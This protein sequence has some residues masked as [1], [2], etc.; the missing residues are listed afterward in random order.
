MAA[1]ERAPSMPRRTKAQLSIPSL[2]PYN[3]Y[4]PQPPA[5]I[6]RKRTCLLGHFVQILRAQHEVPHQQN[7][8]HLG[9][10][11]VQ[12]PAVEVHLHGLGP[13]GAA[14]RGAGGGGEGVVDGRA[15]VVRREEPAGGRRG[16]QG[17]VAVP[18]CC[19]SAGGGVGERGVWAR[20]SNPI[21]GWVV[22]LISP[23]A[24]RT[25][26]LHVPRGPDDERA[27]E[28]LHRY[29][30]QQRQRQHTQ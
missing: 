29:Q 7:Q 10:A 27:L 8:R 9:G 23:P 16:G 5:K 22:V 19:C 1:W 11:D 24:S 17:G 28:G 26:Y 3:H 14:A 15:V 12:N 20:W 13:A 18:V 2:N 30:R 25:S 4:T 21:G 6:K